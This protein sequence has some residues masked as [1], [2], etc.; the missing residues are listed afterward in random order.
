MASARTAVQFVGAAPSIQPPSGS[1]IGAVP[2]DP[3]VR[4]APTHRSASGCHVAHCSP[5][6]LILTQPAPSAGACGARRLPSKRHS[7][8][9]R[10]SAQLPPVRPRM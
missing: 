1:A 3:Q 7:C 5:R 4:A 6:T 10:Q 2:L 9:S 8:S